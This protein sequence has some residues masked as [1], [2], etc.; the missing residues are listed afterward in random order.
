MILLLALS[1]ALRAMAS[2]ELVDV[3]SNEARYVSEINGAP[4]AS[5]LAIE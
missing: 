3:S 2:I 4:E 1:S 5:G